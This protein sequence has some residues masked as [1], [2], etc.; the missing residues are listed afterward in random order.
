MDTSPDRAS[1]PDYWR[2][3]E[4]HDAFANG[5]HRIEELVHREFPNEAHAL[6]DPVSRRNFVKLMGASMMLAGLSNCA[7]QPAE[8][9]IPYVKQ[10]EEAIPGKPAYFATAMTL[11]GYGTGL[12]ATSFQGRPTKIEGLNEHPSSLGA[13]DIHAQASILDLYDPDRQD[14]VSHLGNVSTWATFVSGLALQMA[15]LGNPDGDGLRIFTET[16]TSPT[17]EW[18]M[19]R[20]RASLPKVQW[21][22]HDPAGRDNTRAGARLAFGKYVDTL[23]DFTNANVILSLDANFLTEGPGH[24]R[25][26]RDFAA[27]RDV[28]ANGGTMSRLYAAQSAPTLTGAN[29][30]HTTTLRYPDIETL[31][32]V[33]AQKVDVQGVSAD[34]VATR[35]LSTAWVDAL[36]ADLI[37]NKGH[38]IVLAGEGQPPVVHALAHAINEQLGNV[39]QDSPV[40]HIESVEAEPTDQ[41]ESLAQLVTD[42]NDG[43][44]AILLILGGNPVYNTPGDIDFAAAMDNVPYRVHLSIASNETS[45]LCH[46]LIPEAHYLEAWSDVRGHDGTASIVQ[47]LIQPLYSGKSSHELIAA[48]MGEQFNGSLPIVKEAWRNKHG[49]EAFDPFWYNAVGAG[50]VP[51]SASNTATTRHQNS[52][53]NHEFTP[54]GTGL[55]ILFRLDPNIYDGRFANNAWLQEIPKPLT[56]LTWENAFHIHPQTA[57][58]FE[59]RHE[60][61]I[62]I[63]LNGNTVQGPVL[64]QMGHAKGA[65]TVHL[66]YGRAMAGKIGTGLGF[67]AYGLRTANAPWFGSNAA[68]RQTGRQHLLAKTEEHN[69]IEQSLVEQ[70]QKAQ[71]RHL[72]REATFEHYNTQNE[73]AQHMGHPAPDENNTLYKPDE[74]KYDGPGWG[75]TIDLNRCTGCNVCIAACQSEN[76]IPV[77]GKDQIAKGREMQWIRLDRYYS[78]EIDGGHNA[79][80]DDNLGVAHQPIPCMHCENAPCEPVC[81]V[82][83]TSHSREGLNDMIYNRCIGTRYC[84]N[85]CPYKVRRFNFFKFSDVTTPQLKMM[86]N[87]N[88]TV[89]TRGV[90]EKCTYCVQRINI[91]RIDNKR[92]NIERVEAGLPSQPIADGQIVTACQAACPSQAITFGNIQDPASKVAQAKANPRNYALIG[93]VGTRPRTTYLAKLTNPSPALSSN[94]S[95]T[96]QETSEH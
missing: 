37:G 11:G 66:G 17:L 20:L 18:Q 72:I 50:I 8:K 27:S 46:W 2:T 93:D 54:S 34:E 31:A 91:A 26:A 86:R 80:G 96:S 60:D 24:V 15:G 45:H 65:I 84:A 6:I 49:S 85:N 74:K 22:Q 36:V 35:E 95:A 59:L 7:R 70:G 71:D 53:P 33:V 4:E 32:R 75:M 94:G 92:S 87:P 82:G 39:G 16:V 81:P 56:K 88:V 76:N 51:E 64:Y 77:V 30:D 62:E 47:P 13:T 58:E 25:Y 41:Q 5:D 79:Y 52:F 48:L 40:N 83:A 38:G 29:A 55:D 89:R 10:P 44:V 1:T 28:D 9:I 23:Y 61:F 12:V 68:V 43:K 42:M 90:M 3:L 21:H 19:N 73:F 57:R 63:E 78:G 69:H 14:T 67:D